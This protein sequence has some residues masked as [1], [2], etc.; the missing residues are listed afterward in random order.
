MDH[1]G[2]KTIETKRLILRPFHMNDAEAMFKNWE[3]DPKVTEFLRWETAESIQEADQVLSEW[4][5]G[6]E[7]PDFYQWAIVLKEIGEPIGCISVVGKN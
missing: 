1:K 3:S 5:Q 4:V 7:H 2:T 6:Y